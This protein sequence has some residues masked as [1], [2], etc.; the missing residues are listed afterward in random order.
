MDVMHVM[1]V[2]DVTPKDGGIRSGTPLGT[3][4]RGAVVAYRRGGFG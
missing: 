4:L 2:M 3:P 1:D